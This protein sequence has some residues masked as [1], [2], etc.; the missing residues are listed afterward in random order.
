MKKSVLR[1]FLF[2]MV[3]SSFAFISAAPCDPEVSMINQDPYPA[4]PGDYVRLVFQIDNIANPECKEMTFTLLEQYPLIFDPD[5]NP[6]ITISSGF[7]EKDY[8]SFLIAPYKVRVDKD[9]LNGDN[10]LEVRIKYGENKGYERKEFNLYV[11]DTRTDFEIFVREYDQG[12]QSLIFQV[13]NTGEVDIEALTIEI[14]Q[15]ENIEIKG[16]KTNIVG[17]LDSNEYTTAEFTATPKEGNILL[18]LTYTDK[19]N[20]RRTLEKKV[21]FEPEYFKGTGTQESRP[22]YMYVILV[23]VLGAVVYYFYRRRKKKKAMHHRHLQHHK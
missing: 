11:E 23:I 12:T 20:K 17:D 5:A 16:A 2:V 9:A 8:G 4:I 6:D 19:I 13:L 10:P 1:I 22:T 14:P 7:Y 3:F 21:P 18:K 15:Q